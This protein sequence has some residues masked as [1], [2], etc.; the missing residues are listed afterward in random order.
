MPCRVDNCA[1][2]GHYDCRCSDPH[3]KKWRAFDVEGALCD[4]LTALESS[5][6]ADALKHLDKKTLEWWYDHEDREKDRIKTEALA[7][8]SPR[9]RRALGLK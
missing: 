9:E 4:V 8:L 5:L 3:F 2:C 7:K 1:N 6:G